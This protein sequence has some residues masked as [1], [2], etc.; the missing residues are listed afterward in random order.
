[1]SAK[2][3][4]FNSNKLQMLRTEMQLFPK[5]NA[6]NLPEIQY[7]EELMIKALAEVLA[8]HEW[9]DYEQFANTVDR[10]LNGPPRCVPF[11]I[12]TKDK[13]TGE[14]DFWIIN[15]FVVITEPYEL[16]GKSYNRG[17]VLMSKQFFSFLKMYCI[18]QLKGEV[19]F[20]AFT[21]KAEGRQKLNFE[22]INLENLAKVIGEEPNADNLV[23][24]QFKK[25]G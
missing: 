22:R 15:T 8:T 9:Y 3:T 16:D 2:P 14:F 12:K 23:L 6:N 18:E 25:K 4:V 21:G 17:E 20:W 19:H 24:F 7:P 11:S 13:T 5:S 10:V 1:M